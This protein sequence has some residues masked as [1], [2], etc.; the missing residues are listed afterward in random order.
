[1]AKN[2]Q[3][4]ILRSGVK[5]WNQ[6]LAAKPRGKI[7]FTG[8]DLSGLE[9]RGAIL[10]GADFSGSRLINVDF[11]LARLYGANFINCLL[12]GANFQGAHL[13]EANL[14]SCTLNGADFRN[15]IMILANFENSSVIAVKYN[16]WGAYQ[17]VR[18]S[19]CQGNQRFIRFSNDQ[20]Y[21]EELR[22]HSS[23]RPLITVGKKFHSARQSL[24][25]LKTF[26]SAK[27][28]NFWLIY[29]PWLAS[30]DCG[31]SFTIWFFWSLS[32]ALSFGFI[33]A[34]NP[35]IISSSRD[36]TE[37][38][39]YY[40]SIVSFTTLGFGDV[41]PNNLTGEIILT[42]EVVFGYIMLG[43]LISIFSNKVVR[44]GN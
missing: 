12:L 26:S 28:R 27:G 20:S 10:N 13:G 32:I 22:G 41:V 31:R 24:N 34:S 8:V 7:D 16:R 44:R 37:F 43:G 11:S 19:G 9:L 21:I 2:D 42:L 25:Y 23:G 38:T 33:F 35:E 6:W 17:G 39:P 3:L 5:Q 15:A 29:L 18:L 14:S 40:F 30:S 1:M 36:Q 4:E